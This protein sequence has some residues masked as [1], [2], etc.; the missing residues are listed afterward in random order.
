[1]KLV[2]ARFR[3]RLTQ[4]DLEVM[5]GISASKISLIENGY[6]CL[7]EKDRV[8]LAKVLEVLPED[9]EVEKRSQK[10]F[11]EKTSEMVA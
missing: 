1:M 10:M 3:K 9:L 11:L 8:S 7:Q 2:E 5:T 6:L 4:R